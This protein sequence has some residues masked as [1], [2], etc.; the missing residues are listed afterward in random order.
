LVWFTTTFAAAA[1]VSEKLLSNQLLRIVAV[2]AV[3]RSAPPVSWLE[4]L[5]R[6]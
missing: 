2:P 5:L 1:S 6:K 3:V 4:L